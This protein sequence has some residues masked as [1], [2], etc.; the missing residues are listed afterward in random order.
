V[1]R[2]RPCSCRLFRHGAMSPPS[3]ADR[4]HRLSMPPDEWADGGC[5]GLR[6]PLISVLWRLSA[7]A[8]RSLVGCTGVTVTF[9]VYE[10]CCGTAWRLISS[11]TRNARTDACQYDAPLAS[12]AYVHRWWGV[13]ADGHECKVVIGIH[14]PTPF[15]VM[16][17]AVA[18]LGSRAV[19]AAFTAAMTAYGGSSE[20]LTDNERRSQR[21]V[22][23]GVSG[24]VLIER[25]PRAS[26]ASP[27][28]HKTTPRKAA[29]GPADPRP[30]S[31]LHR[32]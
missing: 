15:V 28:S 32:R 27:R 14:E 21:P 1:H 6:A 3:S 26:G 22:R 31:A 5:D 8:A 25:I 10:F 4:S 29:F 2:G 20:L 17:A 9:G 11:R 23:Q 18:G 7:S 16:A 13:P 19:C 12:V 24:R 30:E